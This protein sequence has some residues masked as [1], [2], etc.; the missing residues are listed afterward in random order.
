M[1][2]KAPGILTF[3]LSVI[4]TVTVLIIKFFGA[5]IP[6]ITGNE[7]WALLFAQFM[8]ILGCIMR[9]L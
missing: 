8:L 4:L 2:L 5:D 6:F 3:M 7:F 9:G 1:G